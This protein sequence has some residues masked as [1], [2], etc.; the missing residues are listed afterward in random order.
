M[1]SQGIDESSSLQKDDNELFLI[2]V[3]GSGFRRY[4]RKGL[5]RKHSGYFRCLLRNDCVETRNG[6]VQLEE[7]DTLIFGEMMS[8][9]AEGDVYD[10]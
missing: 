3:A 9:L 8:Y 6:V 7:A 5:L 2:Q 10:F 4:I 1:T